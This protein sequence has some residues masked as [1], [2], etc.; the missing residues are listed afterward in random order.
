MSA[1]RNAMGFDYKKNYI[2]TEMEND[3]RE[4][5]FFEE[6]AQIDFDTVKE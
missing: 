5:M 2:F 6:V 1:S 3:Q 4:A